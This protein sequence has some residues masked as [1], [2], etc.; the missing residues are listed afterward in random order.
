MVSLEHFLVVG[1]VLFGIGLWI[2]LSKRNAVLILMGIEIMLNAVN[3]TLLAFSR[4]VKSPTPIAGHIFVI[5]VIT[6][7]AA[8]A[9]VALAMVVSVYRNRGTIDVDQ[10]DLLRF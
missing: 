8:E 4:F 1:A 9:S 6:V 2:A 5:F 10:I 3:L 7:A